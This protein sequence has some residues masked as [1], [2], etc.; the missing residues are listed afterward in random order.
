MR[1]ALV[2]IDMQHYFFRTEERRIRINELIESINDLIIYAENKNIPIYQVL[3]IHKEDRSTWN[4]VMK[5]YNFSALIQGSDEAKL[6]SEIKFSD[7][8]IVIT[9]TR[10][11]TFIRTNFEE[12]LIVR[13]IDTLILSGVFTHGCV[14]R[15]AID[16]YER[17]FNVILAKDASFSHL[18]N[19][20][21]AM[22]E[23][24]LN[25]QEQLILDNEQI[26]SILDDKIE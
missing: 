15:T 17:D 5:K 11:S 18:E 19:Q 9:K 3:T 6:L 13:G 4:L 20:E 22:F 25:E 8:H 26:K 2:V 16:A 24:I 7:K 21:Q 10:Q 14:G 12:D 1:P 23:V